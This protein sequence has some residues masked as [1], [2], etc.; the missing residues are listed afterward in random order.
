[1][2][3]QSVTQDGGEMEIQWVLQQRGDQGTNPLLCC[4][5]PAQTATPEMGQLMQAPIK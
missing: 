4:V 1:M 2:E 3:A 5:P